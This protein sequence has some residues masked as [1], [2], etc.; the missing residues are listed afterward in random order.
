MIA[1]EALVAIVARRRPVPLIIYLIGLIAVGFVAATLLAG[2]ALSTSFLLLG[3]IATGLLAAV[4]FVII[5]QLIPND[6]AGGTR[7]AVRIG[8]A[9]VLRGVA[10]SILI[11]VLSFVMRS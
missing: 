9:F 10:F 11:I 2:R 3:C 6:T 1:W 7:T 4:G 8:R 5:W